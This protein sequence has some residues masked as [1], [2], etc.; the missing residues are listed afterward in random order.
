MPGQQ[1]LKKGGIQKEGNVS[2][3]SGITTIIHLGKSTSAKLSPRTCISQRQVHRWQRLRCEPFTRGSQKQKRLVLP[4]APDEQPGEY[5]KMIINSSLQD[6]FYKMDRFSIKTKKKY[7]S[8]KIDAKLSDTWE[9][10]PLLPSAQRTQSAA[11]LSRCC[12]PQQQLP[13]RL[14][15]R[16]LV[17]WLLFHLGL[18]QHSRQSLL[19]SA[20]LENKRDLET[21]FLKITSL[22]VLVF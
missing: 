5:T 8:S 4:S 19:P 15:L 14:A 22:R 11:G 1:L 7:P 13:A 21:E 3:S 6:S 20:S 16:L 17:P 18:P 10:L 2:D 9:S 12:D